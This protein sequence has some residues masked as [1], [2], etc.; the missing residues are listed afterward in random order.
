[1][2]VSTVAKVHKKEESVLVAL[3]IDGI[4]SN[5]LED[6][7]HTHFYRVNPLKF[8]ACQM[9]SVSSFVAP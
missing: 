1:M 2:H 7:N 3:K 4:D 6:S 5:L 8:Y 9:T